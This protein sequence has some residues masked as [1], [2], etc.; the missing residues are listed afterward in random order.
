MPRVVREYRPCSKP[1]LQQH[2]SNV[3]GNESHFALVVAPNYAHKSSRN[4]THALPKSSASGVHLISSPRQMAAGPLLKDRDKD[5][6]PLKMQSLPN[7]ANQPK[8]KH[9]A[10]KLPTAKTWLIQHIR[11]FL[12]QLCGLDL[13]GARPESKSQ[14]PCPHCQ[15]STWSCTS[16]Q[17]LGGE[18]KGKGEPR[19]TGSGIRGVQF[20]AQRGTG[21]TRVVAYSVRGLHV[22][23]GGVL[24][25]PADLQNSIA[26]LFPSAIGCCN[27]TWL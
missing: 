22:V 8:A 1:T 12:C 6:A 5:R 16:H 9:A 21:S 10:K 18:G 26:I 2:W 19:G 4:R 27:V 7:L 14:P 17:E 20:R 24:S 25:V 23:A 15:V 3:S 13:N 11:S